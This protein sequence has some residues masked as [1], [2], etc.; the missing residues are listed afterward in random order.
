VID[1]LRERFGSK[2]WVGLAIVLPLA[3]IGPWLIFETILFG[4]HGPLT[5]LLDLTGIFEYDSYLG[6]HLPVVGVAASFLAMTF[7][8]WM[9]D[10][11]NRRAE[12]TVSV[13]L[14]LLFC[15]NV[16]SFLIGLGFAAR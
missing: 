2:R 8:L 11:R 14:T 6:L 5:G 4:N 12:L 3:V 15:A 1:K 9:G 16:L 10:P 13:L 7:F